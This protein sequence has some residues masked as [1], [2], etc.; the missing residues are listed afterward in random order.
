MTRPTP[1]RRHCQHYV[2]LVERAEPQLFTRG[3]RDW[4]PRLEADVDNLRAALDWSIRRGDPNLALR[5][6]GLSAKFWAIRGTPSE[7]L[8]WLAAALAAAGE[9]APIRDR[10][11]ARRAQVS[12]LADEGAI[13]DAHGLRKQTQAMAVE[14]LVLSRQAGDLVGIA[15]ALIELGYYDATGSLP[16]ARRRRF[17]EEALANAREAQDERLEAHAL[18]ER[19]LAAPPSAGAAELAE[20]E[21]ALRKLGSPRL[22]VSLYNSAAYNAIKEG[23]PEL[24]R[25][26]LDRAIPLI[27]D[28]GDPVLQM[29]QQGNTGL[30]AL[31]SGN[32]TRA[33]AAFEEQL[34]LC[35]E[36]AV[37]NNLACEGLGGMAA[38]AAHRSDAERAARLLGAANA[39]GPVGDADVNGQLE[40]HFFAPGRA[41]HGRR[42]WTEARAAGAQLSFQEAI[43]VALGKRAR[44]ALG[45][46]GARSERALVTFMFTD[47]VGSTRVL[48]ELGDDAWSELL[49]RHDT[50]VREQFLARGGREVKHEATGSSSPS[51]MRP[52]QSRLDVRSSGRSPPIVKRTG[53]FQRCGSA[54]TRRRRRARG[55][56]SQDAGYTK[57][58]ASR[59][60]LRATRCWSV[61]GLST[62]LTG[63]S[64]DA[65]R[66]SSSSRASAR[67]SRSK[68]FPGRADR[69][70]GQRRSG[71]ATRLGAASLTNGH[72]RNRR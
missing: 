53:T 58:P 37:A 26:L 59:L 36:H 50:I 51:P 23:I 48:D 18:M 19:A 2:A 12:L 17:A 44:P 34:R 49:G 61:C 7:A 68:A 46:A 67:R 22:L 57:R 29:L 42:R 16:Q 14:A 32:I 54:S 65:G 66:A 1:C 21:A 72:H 64:R 70:V 47:M 45:V 71:H 69:T 60:R 10:A 15:E 9:D 27:S 4:L 33:E 3:E 35:S 28:L 39:I 40:E 25:P 38:I 31:F 11:R 24:A 5:L 62:P 52:R 30:E 63:G 55:A 56:T 20:A 43:G 13:Y 8:E 41:E 6:A